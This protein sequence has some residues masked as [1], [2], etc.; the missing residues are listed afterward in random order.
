MVY[1][2]F[3]LNKV[4]GKEPIMCMAM[5]RKGIHDLHINF[6]KI[7]NLILKFQPIS[8]HQRSPC[9]LSF[10]GELWMHACISMMHKIYRACPRHYAEFPYK[11]YKIAPNLT[12]RLRAFSR[13]STGNSA[14]WGYFSSKYWP[15]NNNLCPNAQTNSESKQSRTK[16][17]CQELKN[18]NQ[19]YCIRIWNN[20][21]TIN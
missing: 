13:G 2:F 19:Q 5:L 1:K 11:E 9:K 7:V 21:I 15:N 20:Q 16:S 10:W 14:F 12:W 18:T 6:S 3:L 4:G 17:Q 8:L